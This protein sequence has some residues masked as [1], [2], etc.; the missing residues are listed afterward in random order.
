M[1]D[2]VIRA[3]AVQSAP[4]GYTVPGAQ[5]IIVKSVRA[6]VDGSG[7][8]SAF[9]AVLQLVAPDG[10]V[11][12]EAPTDATIAAGGSANV[13]WFP[14]LTTQATA[15]TSQVEW[16]YAQRTTSLTLT[17][18]ANTFIPWVTTQ[19][20]NP[21][22][23]SLINTF[24]L[25]TT[26]QVAQA[27]VCIS[28]FYVIQHPFNAAWPMHLFINSQTASEIG[29]AAYNR[30]NSTDGVDPVTFN[31]YQPR[32]YRITVSQGAPFTIE[33]EAVNDDSVNHTLDFMGMGIVWFPNSSLIV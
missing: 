5:E 33:A 17:P 26:V 13:S 8:G 1:A 14:G 30:M 15:A 25:K 9:L 29:S 7:A 22:L 4:A 20:S 23:F 31:P 32:D 18:S 24:G 11:V 10:S 12:W 27:G 2:E 6:L 19:T 21:A 16:F 3:Q 28:S